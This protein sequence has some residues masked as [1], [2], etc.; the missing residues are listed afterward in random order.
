[1]EL[2]DLWDMLERES[3]LAPAARA[4]TSDPFLSRLAEAHHA[5]MDHRPDDAARALA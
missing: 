5:E 1:M 3:Q 2:A 4:A